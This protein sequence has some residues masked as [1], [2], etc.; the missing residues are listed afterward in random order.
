[1]GS[2]MENKL[3]QLALGRVEKAIGT[4]EPEKIHW[5]SGDKSI[6]DESEDR[7]FLCAKRKSRKLIN[8]Y[9]SFFEVN[10]SSSILPIQ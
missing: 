6:A 3:I 5:V 10:S 9:G 4:F 8:E 2:E 1:M 7:C